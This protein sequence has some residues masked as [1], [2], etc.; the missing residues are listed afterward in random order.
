MV[1]EEEEDV[2]EISHQRNGILL[3]WMVMSR[4]GANN[5]GHVL[6]ISQEEVDVGGML[7]H[8]SK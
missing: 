7:L 3:C 5:R 6:S 8:M 4:V 2:Q 1:L